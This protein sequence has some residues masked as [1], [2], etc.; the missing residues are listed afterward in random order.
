MVK[1]LILVTALISGV[2]GANL[3]EQAT[4]RYVKDSYDSTAS[5][6]LYKRSCE[7]EKNA[8]A[9]YIFALQLERGGVLDDNSTAYKSSDLY[10]KSCNMG[11]MDG[12]KM[13]GDM[14]YDGLNDM[15]QDYAKAME[16]YSK[17]CKAEVSDACL[18]VG[19]LY[20][21]GLGV[22]SD[23]K[24]AA[25][26]YKMACDGKNSDGCY[27]LADMYEVGEGVEKNAKEAMEFY[28]LACDYGASDACSK[29]RKLSKTVDK[30]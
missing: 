18:K 21:S 2:F 12:C 4:K 23:F 3:F 24:T 14:Y 17:A 11:D 26:Y 19:T 25:K 16:F 10:K 30:K 22:E 1:K 13:V 15:K 20:D 27:N 6:E 9:C 5:M 8:A 7:D 29:F 28:G